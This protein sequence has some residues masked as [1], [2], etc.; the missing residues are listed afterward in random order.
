[1][2]PI[3]GVEAPPSSNTGVYPPSQSHYVEPSA[4]FDWYSSTIIETAPTVI[5]LLASR[6][7]AVVQELDKSMNGYTNQCVLRRD[8]DVVARVLYGGNGG[9]PH[10]FASGDY[11]HE[12]A[13]VVR[14][15]WPDTHRVSRC[16]V[17]MDFDDGPGT[18]EF[19]HEFV[20]KFAEDN[21]IVLTGVGDWWT[22]GHPGGRTLYL[23][24]RKSA[25]FVRIYE[26]GKEIRSR[27]LLADAEAAVAHISETLVRVELVVRPEKESRYVA[28]RM[29]P[30]DGYGFARWSQRF[31]SEL[32]GLEVPRV[33]I[34][35]ARDSDDERALRFMVRQYSGVLSR[36]VE[37]R[38]DGSWEALG[39]A[40][41]ERI[42]DVGGSPN[43]RLR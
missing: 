32:F 30:L 29:E 8:G 38:F 35:H 40:L 14:G 10:A 11:S 34:K 28:A 3:S 1:M 36:L 4:R 2:S 43:A 20:K 17:S 21:N 26:K 25:V 23:G 39:V 6:L 5:S 18:F 19:L 33:T 24:S 7:G 27:L 41:G 16:D 31:G 37:D 9:S 22:P 42:N 13:S 15:L 12:F